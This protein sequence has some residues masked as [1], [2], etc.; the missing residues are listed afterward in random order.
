MIQGLSRGFRRGL[1]PK[2]NRGCPLMGLKVIQYSTLLLCPEGREDVIPWQSAS[3]PAIRVGHKVSS[4][5]SMGLW[6][7]ACEGT[8]HLGDVI[9]WHSAA[10]PVVIVSHRL[11]NSKPMGRVCW[12]WVKSTRAEDWPNRQLD[13]HDT[14]DKITRVG[15]FNTCFVCIQGRKKSWSRSAMACLP[16]TL[17]TET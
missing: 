3:L 10:L 2:N 8:A 5:R 12:Y 14:L 15:W 4:P 11:S 17:L 1:W 13:R 6:G 7:W 16:F 9:S